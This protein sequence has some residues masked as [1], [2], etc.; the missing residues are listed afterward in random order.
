MTSAGGGSFFISSIN[1]DGKVAVNETDIDGLV[2]VIRG[3]RGEEG[4]GSPIGENL[5]SI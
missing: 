2:P 3:K 4:V 1:G 5:F